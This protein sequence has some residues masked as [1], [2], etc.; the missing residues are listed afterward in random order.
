MSELFNMLVGWN[1]RSK[2]FKKK[3]EIQRDER[4]RYEQIGHRKTIKLICYCDQKEEF[5]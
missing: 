1:C 3:I 2:D 5:S 4:P